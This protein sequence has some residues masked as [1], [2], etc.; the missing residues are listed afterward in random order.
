MRYLILFLLVAQF[1]FA[2]S[3]SETNNFKFRVYLSDKDTAQFQVSEP[4]TFLSQKAIDRRIVQNVDLDAT[5]FPVSSVYKR[6]VKEQGVAI[7]AESKW[8][9]TLVVQCSDSLQIRDV[10]DLDFVDSVK[11]VWRGK[12]VEGEERMRPRLRTVECSTDTLHDSWFGVS[13][14]QFN[15]H[16]ARNMHKAGFLGQGV[17]IA[18]IDAGFTNVDVIPSFAHSFIVGHKNFVPDGNLFSSLDHGTKVLSTMAINLP[19]KVMGSAP[20]ASYYLLRSEDEQSEFPVEEDYWLSAIEYAD[21]VGV[22]LVNT[23]LGYNEFDDSALDYTHK[24]LTGRN[25][26]ISQAVDL[27]SDKGM[28]IVGSAGNEGN[29]FW[30]KIT[31]PGDSEKMLTIGAVTLDSTIVSFSSTG[32]TADGRIKPDFVSVGSGAITIGQGGEIG[33]DNGT[34]F[35]SPFLAGLIGSLWSVNPQLNRNELIDIVRRSAHQFHNPDTIFGY[36]IPNFEIAYQEVLKTLKLETDSASSEVINVTKAEDDFLLVTLSE[37]M[38]EYHSYFLRVLDE[39]GNIIV[40]DKFESS[41][42]L[43]ELTDCVKKN[44]EELYVVAQSPFSQ[45]TIRIKI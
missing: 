14:P 43:F 31:V 6:M 35:S 18:V 7:V 19:H 10:E 41:D 16:N 26:L 27:A 24:E 11:F 5:D 33:S 12:P 15:L 8:L 42:Y 3:Q 17:D 9:N 38:F 13:A 21:S 1:Q 30:Q 22:R 37:P 23:S 25:A 44:N 34:S 4:L 45:C 29:K 40:S 36:G 20:K 28:L 39:K 32:P 2:V